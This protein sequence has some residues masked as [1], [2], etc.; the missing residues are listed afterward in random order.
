MILLYFIRISLLIA[1]IFYL[2]VGKEV[3]RVWLPQANCE[4]NE[5][6]GKWKQILCLIFF[7]LT[8]ICFRA[9][10]VHKYHLSEK[11]KTERR[12]DKQ[13]NKE[14]DKQNKKKKIS[15]IGG[16]HQF[17]FIPNIAQFSFVLEKKNRKKSARLADNREWLGHSTWKT[18]RVAQAKQSQ[19]A[20][21]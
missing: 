1:E 10:K 21:A 7:F 20:W 19:V 5:W 2:I 14:N 16:F 15:W 13:T 3:T 9:P 6:S 18:T 11:K 12:T 8:F 17:W 4:I